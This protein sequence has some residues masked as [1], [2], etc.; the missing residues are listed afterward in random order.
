MI[1]EKIVST[2]MLEL[3]GMQSISVLSL[4]RTWNVHIMFVIIYLHPIWMNWQTNIFYL[5]AYT[6]HYIQA[7][8]QTDFSYNIRT[9]IWFAKNSFN[10]IAGALG[11]AEYLCFVIAQN[12]K[13]TYNVRNIYYITLKRPCSASILQ[14]RHFAAWKKLRFILWFVFSKHEKHLQLLSSGTENF[15]TFEFKGSST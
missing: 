1:C 4:L 15:I 13:R 2:V 8:R 11:N 3:W 14:Y 6:L 5:C 10:S 7:E 12:V 9:Y